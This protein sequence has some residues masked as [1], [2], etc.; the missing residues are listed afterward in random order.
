VTYGGLGQEKRTPDN[1]DLVTRKRSMFAYE[2][3]VRIVRSEVADSVMPDGGL[4]GRPLAWEAE[5]YIESIRVHPEADHSFFETVVG[6]VEQY[7]PPLR[8]CVEW[9]AMKEAPPF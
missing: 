9:S 2:N 6:V 4:P 7:A 8:N 5:R 1:I 3:E